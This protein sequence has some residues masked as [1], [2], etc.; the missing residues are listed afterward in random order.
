MKAK[1]VIAVIDVGKTNKKLLLFDQEY[2]IAYES[3]SKFD[4]ILD[5]DG[6]PCE[7]LH[8]LQAFVLDSLKS[9][10]NDTDFNIKA[11]NF[12]AYGASFVNIDEAGNPVTPLYNYLKPYPEELK[13]QFYANYGGE[14]Q[15]SSITASPVL[16]NLNSGMQLYRLKYEKPE[17]FRRLKYALHL[18]QYLSL[19]LTGRASSDL[20]SIGCHTNL[21]DF[22]RNE[23][24]SWV[25]NESIDEKLGP[26]ETYDTVTTTKFSDQSFLTGIGLHD[27]SAAL[28][29]YILNFNEPFVL[30][31]SG[32]WCISLNPF[33]S[34]PL[35]PDELKNDCLCYLQYRGQPVKASRLF[36]GKQHEEGVKRIAAHFN[37]QTNKYSNIDFDQTLVKNEDIRHGIF[38]TDS[39]ITNLSVFKNDLEAYHSLVR[40]IIEQQ[41]ISTQFVLNNSPVKRLFVDGGFSANKVYMN[42]LA[43][44]FPEMEVY[45]ASVSQSTALGAALAIHDSWNELPVSNTLVNLQYYGNPGKMV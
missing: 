5:E 7:D 14:A 22:V 41:V 9:I 28:I 31:S 36:A 43:A 11:V 23:Y 25:G 4:E 37:Q 20:T 35:T 26:I 16:G 24:H 18:P 30:I 34:S 8:K 2:K 39:G 32:T 40:N 29:P 21:W 19:L 44:A 10:L 6:F 27:S 1:P 38:Q 12:S 15:F 17:I 3:S 42:L 13:E 33:N 45:A